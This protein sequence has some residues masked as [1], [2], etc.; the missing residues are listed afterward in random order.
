MN[1]SIKTA[2]SVAAN[3]EWVYT[4][5]HFGVSETELSVSPFGQYFTRQIGGKDVLVYFA[6]RGRKAAGS[7][8]AQYFID[9]MNVGKIIVVGTAAGIDERNNILD[10]IIPNTAVQCDASVKEMAPLINDRFTVELPLPKLPFDFKTGVI[11]TTDKPVV[12]WRDHV[13]LRDNGI[14]IAD[15]EAAA[16]AYICRLNGVGC[17]IVKGISDFAIDESKSSLAESESVQHEDFRRN[18]PIIMKRIFDSY[19][20]YLV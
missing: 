10:I 13:E 20:A 16:I 1:S 7:A 18:V 5:E 8:A 15:M 4:L 11:G 19:L 14:T 2:V 17:V 12:M 9:K 3:R 6:G